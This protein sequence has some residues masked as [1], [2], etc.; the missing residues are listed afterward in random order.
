MDDADRVSCRPDFA[1]LI[2]PAYL[3]ENDNLQKVSP[4]LPVSA[5]T[6]PTFIVQTE[7]DPV[8]VDGAIAYYLALR[9]AKV[10]VDMHLYSEGKH[11]YGLRRTSELVTTWPQRVEE[12]LRSR[13]TLHAKS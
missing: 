7:N 11:G 12:W 8:K 13:G 6:P 2:Y 4:E 1:I 5:N 9:Q 3:A 10:P